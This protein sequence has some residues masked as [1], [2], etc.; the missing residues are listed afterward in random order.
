MKCMQSAFQFSAQVHPQVLGP[1]QNLPVSL[2]GPRNAFGL[3]ESPTSWL[4]PARGVHPQLQWLNQGR[5]VTKKDS[6]KEPKEDTCVWCFLEPE[7]V[8]TALHVM[9]QE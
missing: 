4:G 2:L 1:L 5:E 7:F 8:P 6:S 3:G 9:G